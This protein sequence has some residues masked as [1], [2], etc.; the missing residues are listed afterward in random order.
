MLS[1]HLI[2]LIENHAESLTHGVV[3]D[4][5]TNAHTPS[6]VHIPQDELASRIVA[7]YRNLGNWIGEPKDDAIRSEY[8]KWGSIRC[9]Q[10]IPPSELAYCLILTKKHL[11]RYIREH[12]SVVFSGDRIATGELAPLELYSIQELNYL[13]GDFFDRALYYL[14]RGYE[15]Q[16][17]E[18]TSINQREE[19]RR[20][21]PAQPRN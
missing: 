18:P 2:K 1:I 20:T 10:G 6:Q 8:E 12:W 19:F 3:E 15:T 9:A 13:V 4:L 17:A 16:F 5:R 11:R 7:L 14:L 21:L